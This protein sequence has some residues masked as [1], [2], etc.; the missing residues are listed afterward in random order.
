MSEPLPDARLREIAARLA[1]AARLDAGEGPWG[2]LV[3]N[4][5]ADLRDLLEENARLKALL[6]FRDGQLHDRGQ[7]AGDHQRCT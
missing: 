3:N 2:A 1:A 6:D 5:P 7:E 4:A